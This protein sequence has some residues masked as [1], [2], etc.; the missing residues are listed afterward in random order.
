TAKYV[1]EVQ[2]TKGLRLV[3]KRPSHRAGWIYRRAV[4]IP[5]HAVTKK[6][7]GR[8]LEPTA[9]ATVPAT[10]LVAGLMISQYH[11]TYDRALERKITLELHD[12]AEAYEHLID[13]DYRFHAISAALAR[14][15][16]DNTE[17]L[18]EAFLIKLAYDNYY[19]YRADHEA[20]GTDPEKYLNQI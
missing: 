11:Y 18:Q 1:Q 9:S 14:G 7:L 20:D 10:A 19:R 4:Q 12:N 3:L 6:L 15:E 16:I 8:D 17:A 5:S 13:S 2:E